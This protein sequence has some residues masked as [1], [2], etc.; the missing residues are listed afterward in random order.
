MMDINEQIR[1]FADFI[2]KN[3]KAELLEKVRKGENFLEVDFFELSKFNPEIADILLDYPEDTIKTAAAAIEQFDLPGEAKGFAVRVKNLPESQ[4][5]LIRNI[6][7]NHL[8]KFL[9]M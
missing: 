5:I 2:E 3:Y 7:S 8:E 4:K 6:R 9:C 1:I